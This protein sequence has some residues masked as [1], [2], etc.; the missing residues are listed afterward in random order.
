[1]K[2]SELMA[3]TVL[4][5]VSEVGRA[6]IAINPI[7]AVAFCYTGHQSPRFHHATFAV[8]DLK[9]TQFAIDD[10]ADQVSLP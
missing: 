2:Q 1:M 10:F 4:A 7:K 6:L 3:P 8:A 5:E 9:E